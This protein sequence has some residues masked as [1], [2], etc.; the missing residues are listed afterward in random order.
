MAAPNIRQKV[1][2]LPNNAQLKTTLDDY[3]TQGFVLHQMINLAPVSNEIL[4]VYYDP[5]VDPQPPV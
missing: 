3:M 5:A 4:I 2:K 1:A